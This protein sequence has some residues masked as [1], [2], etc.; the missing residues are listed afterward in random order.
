MELVARPRGTREV[1]TELTDRDM[2]CDL[3]SAKESSASDLVHSKPPPIPEP[4]A[5]NQALPTS[6]SL[7][8]SDAS[9]SV[10]LTDLK[11]EM[12]SSAVG[13]G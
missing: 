3:S 13:V 4:L 1:P 10:P 2:G 5:Q 11:Y 8:Q 9:L 12:S 7:L 6:D